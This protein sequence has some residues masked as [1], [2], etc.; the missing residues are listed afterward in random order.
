MTH[1]AGPLD[2]P[3][4]IDK[5]LGKDRAGKGGG[6]SKTRDPGDEFC[7]RL[8][9]ELRWPK[10]S[11]AA[12]EAAFEA[13]QRVSLE[14]DSENMVST[15]IKQPEGSAKICAACGGQNRET[16]KFCGLCGAPLLDQKTNPAATAEGTTLQHAVPSLT[17]TNGQHHYYHHYHHHFFATGTGSGY[18]EPSF[19]PR[20]AS[21]H[22]AKE[23]IP[24]RAPLSAPA[25]S[26]AEA[27]IRKQ[28]QALA[29]ACN[30]RQLDDL[31][32]V[33]AP[34]ALL[35]R[36]NTPPV[37]GSAAIREHFFGLLE[38]GFGEVEL[39]PLR[40]EIVGDMA[41]E[42]GRCKTLVPFA[43]G[44]R[45]E[46]RGKY[47]MVYHR[48]GNDEWKIMVDCWSSDLSIGV[49]SEPEPA[50]NPLPPRPGIPRKSA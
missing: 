41:Y 4:H 22:P 45:R 40:V 38:S 18:P 48:R 25:I 35:L 2:Q 31:V 16:N 17:A 21:A 10:P 49:V 47:L 5:Q 14:T 28:T 1:Q 42:A 29:L 7:E 8:N 44:K 37:R 24:L 26:R 15:T 11:Q 9:S 39:D 32:D 6:E 30:S 34:D 20:V 23:L 46:E 13:M 50:K 33:Y 19:A 43:I 36:P 12:L 27:T 3:Q